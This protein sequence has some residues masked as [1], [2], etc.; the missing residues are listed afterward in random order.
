M[1]DQIRNQI[2][3][4]LETE[5]SID[6]DELLDRIDAEDDAILAELHDLMEEGKISYNIDWDI[7]G[8]GKSYT[9]GLIEDED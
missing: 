9:T 4:I 6:Q 5:T 7:D 8:R 1:T 2:Q 3:S